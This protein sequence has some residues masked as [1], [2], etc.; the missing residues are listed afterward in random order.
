MLTIACVEDELLYDGHGKSELVPVATFKE[1]RYK[2]ALT[3]TN[4]HK[5]L[6]LFGDEIADALNKRVVVEVASVK[7]GATSKQTI[8]ITGVA[9]AQKVDA[10]TG[11][12]TEG[13]R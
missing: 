6:D 8:R 10:K 7:V 12:I 4:R 5:L 1:C 9:P 3:N 2:L 11:E 13:G